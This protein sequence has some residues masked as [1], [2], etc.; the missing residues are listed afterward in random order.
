MSLRLLVE[1]DLAMVRAWRNAPEVRKSM[2]S[3]HE[4]SETEH[5]AWFERIRNDS[6][7]RWYVHHSC[8]GIADGVVY[9]TQYDV[10]R[11]SAFW[12]FY[13][14]PDA[15]AGTGTKLGFDALNEAFNTLGLHKLNA[16]VLITNKKS[17]ALHTKIGFVHEGIFRDSHF[18][19]N[20]YI[21][22]V[23]L[24]IL[25]SEWP[26]HKIE[27]QRRMDS[28]KPSTSNQTKATSTDCYIVASAKP[29]HKVNFE[30]LKSESPAKWIWVSTAEELAEATTLDTPRY[31]FFLHWNW[32]VPDEIWSRFECVCFHMTDVP[33]GRGGSPLQNLIANGHK[34]TKLTALRMIE[35]MDAGPVYIK[36]PLSLA[37]RAEEIYKRAGDLSF[38]IIRWMTQA[39]PA[40]TPQEGEV[41][42]FKRRKPAQSELPQK[43]TLEKL[44][45]HIRMLDAPTYPLGFV[46]HGEFVLEFYHARLDGD[47]LKAQV[48]IHK[49]TSTDQESL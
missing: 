46:Q 19:G 2:Y 41:T 43:G 36:Q 10:K 15:A 14:A 28:F 18:D 23:R 27:I 44:Y 45:D 34:E 32:L 22:V 6:S 31:I 26:A 1:S 8:E 42:I 9:F 4:I 48:T 35:T 49:R 17:L 33:Y 38:E 37:G 20:C 39:A 12:G 24:G 7:S 11:R 25:A 16:E 21:D 47:Q 29:W 30:I 40:P 5:R 3:T 13:A